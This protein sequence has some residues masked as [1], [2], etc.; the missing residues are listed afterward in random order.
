MKQI[1]LSVT[2]YNRFESTVKSFAN[3]LDDE[4]I[5]E[6]LVLDDCST[7][8]SFS[9]LVAHFDGNEKVKVLQQ[10][11]NRSM[12]QNKADAVMLSKFEWCILLDSD[13][14]INTDYIDNLFALPEWEEGTIYAPMRAKPKFIYDAFAGHTID[15]V[16]V[17]KYVN[18]PLFGALINTSNYFVNRDFYAD[19]YKFNPEIKGTDTA[20][21][22]VNH[23]SAGGSFHVVKDL[24]YIH[25]ISTDSEF[26]KDIH[27][28]MEQ[29]KKID[30][31]LLAM[32]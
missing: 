31:K 14:E 18:M 19:V 21:H 12:Q 22:F 32:Q 23:I 26:M 8:D 28:N 13:N 5:G 4:R 17:H 1:S 6:I 25:A 29:A 10:V 30:E 24:E 2:S 20:N 15:K 16:N 9:K 11:F 27:Y 3:V 7:D